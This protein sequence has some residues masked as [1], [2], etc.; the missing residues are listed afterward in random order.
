[1]NLLDRIFGPTSLIYNL[2]RW[3][4]LSP[5]TATLLIVAGLMAVVIY[6][7][8]ERERDKRNKRDIAKFLWNEE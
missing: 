7:Y 1:M 5:V 4:G 8:I 6:I 2:V 3:L